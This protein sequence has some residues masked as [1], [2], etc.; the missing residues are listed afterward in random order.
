MGSRS[1]MLKVKPS[2]EVWYQIKTGYFKKYP[3]S[4]KK[5]QWLFNLSQNVSNKYF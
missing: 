1:K 4:E 3:S 5:S 2:I